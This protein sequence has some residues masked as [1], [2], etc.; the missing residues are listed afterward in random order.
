MIPFPTEVKED[1]WRY[2]TKLIRRKS[3]GKQDSV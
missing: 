2:S 1:W 3:T